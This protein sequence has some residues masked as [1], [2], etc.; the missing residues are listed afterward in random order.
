[1]K[2]KKPK[3]KAKWNQE[4]VIRGALRRAFSRSPVVQ[5]VKKAVRKEEKQY[6][7]DGSL[8]KKPAVRFQCAACKKWFM[9]KDV[10]VDHVSPVIST[11]EAK[12]SWDQFIE[13]LFCAKENL[14]VL[15]SFKLKDKDKHGG[16]PSCHHVKTQTERKVRSGKV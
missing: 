2:S 1:M 7:K 12:E 14:Q 11:D 8:A 13:K 6:N 15:C 3:K 9:G 4:A 16:Q 10:A 5:E